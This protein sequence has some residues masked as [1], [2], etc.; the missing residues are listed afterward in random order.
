MR[1]RG[2]EAV[3]EKGRY[4]CVIGLRGF[5][6]AIFS[7]VC[8][9]FFLAG[10][11]NK[12][13]LSLQH[14][15]NHCF[16]FL[17]NRLGSIFIAGGTTLPSRA[18]G[19]WLAPQIPQTPPPTPCQSYPASNPHQQA[20]WCGSESGLPGADGQAWWLARVS[21]ILGAPW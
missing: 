18:G 17:N 12:H 11:E 19:S 10:L 20:P 1:G 7:L 9:E 4:G 2:G 8:F 15:C 21:E 16:F 13:S 3:D 6:T 14:E 5:I